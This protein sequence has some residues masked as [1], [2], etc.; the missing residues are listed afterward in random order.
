MTQYAKYSAIA[1]PGVN[2]AGKLKPD[3]T[4]YYKYVLGAFNTDNYSGTSYPLLP[5]VEAL[6]SEGGIVRRRLDSGLCKGEYGHPKI[7]GMSLKTALRRL[8]VIDPLLVC[9]HIRSIQL[10]PHKDEYGKDIILSMGDLKPTGPYGPTLESQMNNLDENIAFSI[11]SFT[12]DRLIAGKLAKVVVDALTYDYVTEPGISSATKFKTA[13][14]EELFPDIIFSEDELENAI[15]VA[16]GPMSLESDISTLKMVRTALGW[17][18][19]QVINMRAI[20]W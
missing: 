7:E 18:K 20:D 13:S 2:Q 5:S 17:H 11:R 1:M 16:A 15:G 10:V 9:H 3:N 14:L 4:G 6:F 19:V 12:N 8:S